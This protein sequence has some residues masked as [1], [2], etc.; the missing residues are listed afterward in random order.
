MLPFRTQGPQAV[1]SNYRARANELCFTSPHLPLLTS[2]IAH[3]SSCPLVVVSGSI[4][5]SPGSMDVLPA[6]LCFKIFHLLDH[7]ALAAA[8]QGSSSRSK[9]LPLLLMLAC[10]PLLA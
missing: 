4:S 9:S 6:E 5:C 8:P 10:Y 3:S 7:Q 2:L 1:A